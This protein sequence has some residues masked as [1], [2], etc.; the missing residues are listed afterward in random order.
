MEMIYLILYREENRNYYFIHANVRR[1][2][3]GSELQEI[4]KNK[5]SLNSDYFRKIKK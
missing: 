4:N 2:D 1:N 3:V 5:C